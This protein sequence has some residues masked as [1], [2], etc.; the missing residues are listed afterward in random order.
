MTR[1]I[2]STGEEL[3][4]V[5]L[6]TWQTFDVGTVRKRDVMVHLDLA[7]AQPVTRAA[8]RFAAVVQKHEAVGPGAHQPRC[9]PFVRALGR[10]CGSLGRRDAD[11]QDEISLADRL[12]GPVV[13]RRA[14][15][16]AKVVRRAG[17]GRLVV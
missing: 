3:P 15:D 11:T 6:G 16:V 9:E 5:G 4:A 8:W 2:P 17:D 1:K 10:R 13:H 14:G 12:L 7:V